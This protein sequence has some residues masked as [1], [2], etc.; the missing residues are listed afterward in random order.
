MPS[1][2]AGDTA[3]GEFGNLSGALSVDD[4]DLTKSSI[5]AEVDATTINTRDG[6]RDEHLKSPDFFD[7]AKYP[8]AEFSSTKI[9]AKA[10]GDANYEIT[11]DLDL[12]GVKK[13][14]S[15]PAKITVD[16][17]GA[18]GTA[19]FKI[20]R[21]DFQ[22]VYAGKADDLIKDEVLLKISLGFTA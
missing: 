8:K 5:T 22:I 13:S 2:G 10:A 19:E 20:N 17:R 15:F 12:H 18:K 21:K 6:K 7:V 11:G 3:R 14:I 1:V 16:E 4:A 9:E